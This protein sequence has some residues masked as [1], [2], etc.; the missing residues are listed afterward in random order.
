MKTVSRTSGATTLPPL[1]LSY[2]DEVNSAPWTLAASVT[3][4]TRTALTPAECL[5]AD[6]D[7][8]SRTD[9]A[10]TTDTSGIWHVGRSAGSTN[11]SNDPTTITQ[12]FNGF[13]TQPWA[14]P[15]VQKSLQV[16]IPFSRGSLLAP[17]RKVTI[18]DVGRSCLAADLN[19]DN[20]ADLFCYNASPSGWN[21]G[22]SDGHAFQVDSWAGGPV[23]D[24]GAGTVGP[25]SDRCLPGDYDGDGTSDIACLVT[26]GG[27]AQW[28]VALSSGHG[29]AVAAW[30]GGES[31]LPTAA[32]TVSGFCVAGNFNGDHR[33]DI[34]CY[35]ADS[36]SWHVL[37]SAGDAFVVGSW[38]SGPTVADPPSASPVLTHC[39]SGDFNGDGKTDLACYVGRDGSG[40]EFDGRWSIS[41]STGSGWHT[42]DWLGVPV[43]QDDHWN[44]GTGCFAGD[45]NGDGRTDLSCHYGGDFKYVKDL[46]R[47]PQY[48]G[49]SI[50]TGTGFSSSLFPWHAFGTDTRTPRYSFRAPRV[51]LTATREPIIYATENGRATNITYCFQIS[52]RP[53]SLLR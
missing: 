4:P 20:R 9:L 34:A 40:V 47:A 28:S 6:F 48:W 24:G 46:P 30:D 8:D 32:S 14:G 17:N 22:L 39:L 19:G 50:A 23:L 10:C 3:G 26:S 52:V 25:L 41:L 27:S 12:T 15:I 35:H 49:Q 51:T 18:P 7:G 16:E 33:A 36:K 43:M 42:G 31:P 38:G 45:F 44:V 13:D 53:M 21:V 11:T 5:A 37:L 29:W 2:S 1:S